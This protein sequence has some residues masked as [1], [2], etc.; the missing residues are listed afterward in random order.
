MTAQQQRDR[1]ALQTLALACCHGI[2]PRDFALA[3]SLYH[4]DGEDHHGSMFHG[5]T[6]AF[7]TWL[8][9]VLVG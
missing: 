4:D 6:D 1:L 2:K 5:T 8:S 9:E 7:V 3:R